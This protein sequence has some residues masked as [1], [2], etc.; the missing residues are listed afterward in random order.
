MTTESITDRGTAISTGRK[1][2]NKGTA[3]NDSPKPNVERTKDAIKLMR[4][5]NR[6]VNT[7]NF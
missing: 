4:R 5:I 1:K 3:I 7:K 6:T 2:R